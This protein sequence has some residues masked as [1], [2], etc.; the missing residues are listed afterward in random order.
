LFRIPAFAGMT[1]EGFGMH[2]LADWDSFYVI[3]GSAAGALIGLQ[4]V[5][6]TL[7]AQRPA[8]PV[9]SEA[10]NAFSTPTIVHFGTAL[11]LAALLRAPWRTIL[12]PAILWGVTGL[13]G[14]AYVLV[15]V[16]RMRRQQAYRPQRE[17]WL[18]HGLLPALA[19]AA[20][21]ASAVAAPAATREA[22]FAVGGAA[23]L[24]LF[25][26]I[27]N[28]WDGVAWHVFFGHRDDR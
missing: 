10:G 5:V 2:D 17:D 20:L 3:T 11:L 7:I 18:F 25:T 21:A 26:G 24:L 16:R 8:T 28:A 13:A 19:Y 23:L 22:L 4:F 1:K 9:A 15:T 27:H 6:L 14:L 12:P